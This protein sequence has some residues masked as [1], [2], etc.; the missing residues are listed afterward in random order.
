MVN[1]N[2]AELHNYTDIIRY[3][4]VAHSQLLL[5]KQ[6]IEWHLAVDLN[7]EPFDPYSLKFILCIQITQYNIFSYFKIRFSI[8]LFG[9]NGSFA[10]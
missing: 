9:P 5:A 1:I 4:A 6:G 3:L 2:V 7:L 8:D 10:T